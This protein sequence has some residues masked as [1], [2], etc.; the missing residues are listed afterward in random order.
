M[1][2]VCFSANSSIRARRRHVA[3]I[4]A[5]LGESSDA[6][7][8]QMVADTILA[9]LRK[10]LYDRSTGSFADGLDGPTTEKL[11]VSSHSSIHSI[12]FPMVAGV[13][14]EVSGTRSTLCSQ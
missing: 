6:Q 8:Y 2:V 10:R 4:A 12:I 14:N 3:G 13:V 11:V 7:H 1:S 5:L 9:T